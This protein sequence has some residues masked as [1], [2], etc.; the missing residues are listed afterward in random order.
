MRRLHRSNKAKSHWIYNLR[1]IRELYG[2]SR[3]TPLNWIK[4]GLIP[5]DD[6]RPIVFRGDELNRFHKGRCE[7]ARCPLAPYELYC[8]GCKR[9]KKPLH[10]QI[11]FISFRG[12]SGQV[13][14][15]CPD[16]SSAIFRFVTQS[17]IDVFF[18]RYQ[19]KC[20]DEN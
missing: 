2:V 8:L 6:Q 13:T 19:V 4:Q 9:P 20:R 1:S 11:E 17:S 18:T 7:R 12:R 16:C 15:I 3:N 10:G 5:V 14:G